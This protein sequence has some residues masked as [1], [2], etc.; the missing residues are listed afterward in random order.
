[1]DERHLGVFRDGGRQGRRHHRLPLRPARGR[2]G[3][4]AFTR[5]TTVVKNYGRHP[6]RRGC[7][8]EAIVSPDAKT[9]IVGQ[10]ERLKGKSG[11][12]A[13]RVPG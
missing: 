9:R 1:M 6:R 11:C 13:I 12:L 2:L 5:A 7:S 3:D 10:A 4:D 8:V